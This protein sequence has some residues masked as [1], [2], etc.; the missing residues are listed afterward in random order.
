MKR[1]NAPAS[2]VVEID[3]P[4]GRSPRPRRSPTSVRVA[5]DLGVE[6]EAADLAGAA[7]HFQIEA[8]QRLA[9]E[10][11]HGAELHVEVDIDGAALGVGLAAM[12][13]RPSI[14]TKPRPS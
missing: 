4:G 3:A 6:A 1:K 9:V 7:R 5:P 2:V 12:R 8:A 10:A 11:D 13:R 14:L